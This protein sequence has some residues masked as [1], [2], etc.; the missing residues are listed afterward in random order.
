[1]YGARD[2]RH[3]AAVVLKELVEEVGAGGGRSSS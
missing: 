2:E 1:V 3:N